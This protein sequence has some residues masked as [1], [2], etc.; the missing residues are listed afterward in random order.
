MREPVFDPLVL[1]ALFRQGYDAYHQGLS[2]ATNPHEHF[3]QH[4]AWSLGWLNASRR[5]GK[6]QEA[7]A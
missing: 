3:Y 5:H 7:V 1:L 4:Q 2:L 6:D